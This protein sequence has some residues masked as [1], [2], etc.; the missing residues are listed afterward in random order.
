MSAVD[1][2]KVQDYTFAFNVANENRLVE[3]T[4]TVREGLGDVV[5]EKPGAIII[6]YASREVS[7][8]GEVRQVE[9]DM[10]TVPAQNIVRLTRR[11]RYEPR[12]RPSVRKYLNPQAEI[13]ALKK[14]LESKATK[15]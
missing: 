6:Q 4:Y 2:V 8:G 9:G 5:T 10:V 12:E 11:W 3:E 13:E 15:E 1:F 7:V 14:E